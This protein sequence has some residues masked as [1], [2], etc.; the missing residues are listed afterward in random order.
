MT[1]NNPMN[2]LRIMSISILYCIHTHKKFSVGGVPKK[3]FNRKHIFS[4]YK[5]KSTA[6]KHLSPCTINKTKEIINLASKERKVFQINFT[7]YFTIIHPFQKNS[8]P[9]GTA[10]V[11]DWCKKSWISTFLSTEEEEE[12]EEQQQQ[13]RQTPVLTNISPYGKY[14]ITRT[15]FWSP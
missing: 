4:N 7:V 15:L 5:N 2:N 1:Y 12:E 10:Y 13:R 9:L 14:L 6:I 3:C 8:I 11:L